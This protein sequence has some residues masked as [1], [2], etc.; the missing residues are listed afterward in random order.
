M[1][2]LLSFCY[3][4]DCCILGITFCGCD[5]TYGIAIHEL[6]VK[7]ILSSLSLQSFAINQMITYKFMSNLPSKMIIQTKMDNTQL[8]LDENYIVV[9]VT[10]KLSQYAFHQETDL[11][12]EKAYNL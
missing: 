6:R 8:L 1:I 9:K 3:I 2:R 11:C 4:V 7:Y 5:V 10:V 12:C